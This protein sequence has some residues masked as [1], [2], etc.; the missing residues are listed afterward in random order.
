VGK[1]G[2]VTAG[3]F[4]RVPYRLY[5][6]EAVYRRE[7]ERIFTGPTWSFLGFEAEIPK[8]GD[9]RTGFVGETPIIYNRAGDGSVRAFVNRCSHRGALLR[10]EACGNVKSHSCIYHAWTYDLTGDLVG[11]PFEHGINGES[12]MPDS[13][14]RKQCGL[15]KMRVESL[16]GVLFGTFS[17]EAEPLEDYLGATHA[18]HL[19]RIFNRPI[20]ILGYQRQHIRGNWKMYHENVRDHYHGALLHQFQRVFGINR[21]SHAAGSRM[22]SR[23]RHGL[24]FVEQPADELAEQPSVD[25]R[26]P[27][28]S[29]AEATGAATLAL[30]DPTLLRFYPEF[31]DRR[32]TTIAA[33]FPNAVFQQIRNALAARQIHPRGPDAFDLVFTLFG[34]EDDSE[35]MTRHRLRQ[36]NLAGPGGLIS[37]EDGEAIEICQDGH[38]HDPGGSIVQMGGLGPIA[39]NDVKLDDVMLRGFWAYYAEIMELP[40]AEFAP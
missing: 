22:D 26:T 14:D 5:H 16:N 4:G 32:T 19:R 35:E 9:F 31:P 39:D 7:L 3:E 8:P 15:P 20:R 10:R 30:Q 1:G 17:T 21:V 18:A 28:L 36:A 27:V 38:R 12:G 2:Q 11:V 34:Y 25:D 29:L 37:L 24:L 6:D 13:F 40:K 33:V 23:F